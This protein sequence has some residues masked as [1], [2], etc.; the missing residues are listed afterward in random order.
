MPIIATVNTTVECPR[1]IQG[2]GLQY[3]LMLAGRVT[4]ATTNNIKMAGDRVGV[5]VGLN[6]LT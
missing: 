6:M 1:N 4:Q 3:Q 2:E 5:L